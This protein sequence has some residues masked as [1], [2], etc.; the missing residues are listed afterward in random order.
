MAGKL[1]WTWVGRGKWFSKTCN[2]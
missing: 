1:T 2:I